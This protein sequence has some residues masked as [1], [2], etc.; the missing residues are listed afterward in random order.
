[1]MSRRRALSSL[2]A[3]LAVG[4]WT[5]ACDRQPRTFRELQ[6][7][8]PGTTD[9]AARTALIEQYIA[10]RSNPI[11][12]DNSRLVFFVKDDGSGRQPRIIGRRL[13]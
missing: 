10:G 2:L 3:L 5:S 12:E 11:I 9:P 1:M 4:A 6:R 13:D 7:R 8:L